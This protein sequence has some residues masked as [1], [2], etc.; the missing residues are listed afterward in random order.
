MEKGQ[1]NAS[2]CQL[3]S[4]KEE[5]RAFCP[6]IENPPEPFQIVL[7]NGISKTP[8]YKSARIIYL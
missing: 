6:E 8:S 4:I 5:S 2:D 3:G 7:R 1:L